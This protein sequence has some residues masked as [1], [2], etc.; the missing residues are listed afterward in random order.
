MRK[1]DGGGLVLSVTKLQPPLR[2]PG[3]GKDFR[4]LCDW[5]STEIYKILVRLDC[6]DFK[7]GHKCWK[8]AGFQTASVERNRVNVSGC[9]NWRLQSPETQ[10]KHH[11]RV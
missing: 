10:T 1:Q 6:C 11:I 2:S 7:Q 4:N 3:T 9:S 5:R 8:S